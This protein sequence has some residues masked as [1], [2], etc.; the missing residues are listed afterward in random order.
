MKI[1]LDLGKVAQLKMTNKVFIRIQEDLIIFRNALDKQCQ[2]RDNS[3]QPQAYLL[4]LK[5]AYSRV[6]R[7][8]MWKILEKLKMPRSVISKLR[9]HMS[10]QNIK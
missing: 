10:S 1:K 4:D 6:S 8:I 7:P 5:K 3:G 9:I 2:P